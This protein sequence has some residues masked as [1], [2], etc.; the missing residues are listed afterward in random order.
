V[1][2]TNFVA[3]VSPGK[4]EQKFQDSVPVSN[5]GTAS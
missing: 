1:Y 2:G 4:V 3:G 5:T